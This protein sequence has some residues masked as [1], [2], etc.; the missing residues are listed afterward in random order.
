MEGAGATEA[1]RRCG[2]VNVRPEGSRRCVL[3]RSHARQQTAGFQP[4]ECQF[5][6]EGDQELCLRRSTN[7]TTRRTRHCAYTRGHDGHCR[8]LAETE[9]DATREEMR[10]PD[11]DHTATTYDQQTAIVERITRKIATE[12]AGD[13]EKV[14]RAV[15]TAGAAHPND[16]TL[17]QRPE[18]TRLVVYVGRPKLPGPNAVADVGIFL[19]DELR[20]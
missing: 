10:M 14:I 16:I 6:D 8:Y 13:V 19:T 7:F 15:L 11:P 5:S 2:T 4:L 9:R 1:A 17:E 20:T 12:H 18:G 3:W